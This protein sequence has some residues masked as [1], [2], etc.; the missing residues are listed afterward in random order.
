MN[1]ER[2]YLL[3]TNALIALGNGDR[4]LQAMLE[5]A[6]YVATSVICQLE[7]LAGVAHDDQACS[8]FR[9]MLESIDVVDLRHV[10]VGLTNEI[11]GIRA[12]NKHIKLPDAIVMASA[13]LRKATLVTNDKQLQGAGFCDIVGF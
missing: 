5:S 6:Q 4:S 11:I 3:D 1:G 8:A 10:D 7:Y 2:R 12:A 13:K 9:L